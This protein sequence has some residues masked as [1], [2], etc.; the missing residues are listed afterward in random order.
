L[1]DEVNIKT[2]AT[3][4]QSTKGSGEKVAT[5]SN[6]RSMKPQTVSE[7]VGWGAGKDRYGYCDE[8]LIRVL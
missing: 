8:I 6:P 7:I 2:P 5:M 1:Q 4:K 3:E